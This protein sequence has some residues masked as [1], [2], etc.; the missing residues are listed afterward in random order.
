MRKNPALLAF[1]DYIEEFEEDFFNRKTE[2]YGDLRVAT[3]IGYEGLDIPEDKLR[4]SKKRSRPEN[5]NES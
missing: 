4:P 2:E 1:I 3:E 5:Q